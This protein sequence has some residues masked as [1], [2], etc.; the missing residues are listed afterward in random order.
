MDTRIRNVDPDIWAK[1]KLLC[2]VEDVSMNTKLL[3]LVQTAVE[4]AD[5]EHRQLRQAFSKAAKKK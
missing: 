2:M 3:Q 5:G 4:D 1:F